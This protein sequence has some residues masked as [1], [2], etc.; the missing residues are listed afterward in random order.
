MIEY[1]HVD[2]FLSNAIHAVATQREFDTLPVLSPE[3][4]KPI[5]YV[6]IEDL[7]K[8]LEKGQVKP[9]D[10]LQSSMRKFATKRDYQGKLLTINIDLGLSVA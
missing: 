8:R 3:N 7:L 5:G 2:T 10:S 6:N 9:E 4:R 1:H